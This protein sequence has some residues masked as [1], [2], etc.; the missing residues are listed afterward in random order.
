M[1]LHKKGSTLNMKNYRPISL[2]SIFSKIYEKIMYARLYQFLK[3]SDLFSSLQFGFRGKH[4]T[5]HALINITE[6]IKESID[7]NKFGCG[8]FLDLRKAIDTVNHKILLEKRQHYGV[9]G[10]AFNWFQS[11]LTNEKQYVE[12]NDASS[13]LVDVMCWVPQGSVLGPLLFL[14]FINDLPAV[15]KKLKI[16]LFADDTNIYL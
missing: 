1:P 11:Y 6:T 4:S 5:N 2:L 9:R 12:V 7:N 8:V 15:C 16:Y 10:L 13:D 14:V 3:I